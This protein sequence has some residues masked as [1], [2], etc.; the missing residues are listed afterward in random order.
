MASAPGHLYS[1]AARKRQKKERAARA[2]EECQE[3]FQDADDIP[4]GVEV[5]DHDDCQ[6]HDAPDLPY[7]EECYV[8][9]T[10]ADQ[11]V[12]VAPI[13]EGNILSEEEL[14]MDGSEG[15]PAHEQR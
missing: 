7:M 15:E 8:Q 11:V 12:D 1:G 2:D 6:F 5:D 10:A 9:L 13:M 14:R 4:E 3:E